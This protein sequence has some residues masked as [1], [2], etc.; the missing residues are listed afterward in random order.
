MTIC[1]VERKFYVV[2]VPQSSLMDRKYLFGS[3]IPDTQL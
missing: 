1:E 3:Y 2:P